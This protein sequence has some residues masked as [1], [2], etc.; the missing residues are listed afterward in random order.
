MRFALSKTMLASSMSGNKRFSN[1]KLHNI[2]TL[3]NLIF[4]V[5]VYLQCF[6]VENGKRIFSEWIVDETE[7]ELKFWVLC[8]KI[9]GYL[10]VYH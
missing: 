7:N 3:L 1:Y 2:S 5:L 9:E 4:L 6:V 10:I 8:A